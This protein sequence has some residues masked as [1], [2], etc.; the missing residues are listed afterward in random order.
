MVGF[1]IFLLI[2]LVAHGYVAHRNGQ[3]AMD[4]RA[5]E[6]DVLAA[7]E[8]WRTTGVSD[9][10]Q[11]RKLGHW[12]DGGRLPLYIRSDDSPAEIY[13]MVQIFASAR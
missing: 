11:A 1:F 5:K 7:I 10:K 13:R 8:H 3:A 6:Q 4:V 2:V 9:Q 12:G